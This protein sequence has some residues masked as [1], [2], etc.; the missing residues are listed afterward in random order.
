MKETKKS[1]LILFFVV[2]FA[3]F[4]LLSSGTP[5]RVHS[6]SSSSYVGAEQCGTCHPEQYTNWNQ[7]DHANMAG[8]AEIN[9]SGT[10]YWV[11][12]PTNV[13]NQTSF[14]NRCAKCH[15]TGW[16]SDT[17]TWPYWNSTDP[18]LAGKFLNV[19]CEK[20]HGPDTM[21]L[22]VEQRINYSSSLCGE[23]HT[24]Y[25]DWQHSAHN[26]SLT[27]LRASEHAADYC[28]RC[29]ST[30][31]F[32][33]YYN[34]SSNVEDV[35]GK[36]NLTNPELDPI[37]CQL[38]HNPHSNQ[39]EYQLRFENSTELCGQCHTGSHHPQYETFTE[40]PHEKAGLECA[41][42]HGQGTRLFHGAEESWFNH[43]FWIYNTFYPFN[44]TDPV[45]CSLCHTRSWATSQ[46]GVIQG[47]TTNLI[48][49]VTQAVD[50]AKT[51]INIANQTS[52]VN[53][54]QIDLATSM[55][56]TAETYI[57]S[58]ENDRSEGF[59]NP[60]QTFATLS[61]AAHLANKA[62]LLAF[63]ALNSEKTT[64]EAQVLSLQTQ[65][66]SL[67]NQTATLQSSIDSLEAKIDSLESTV[68][69]IPYLYGGI[70]LAIGFIIGAA[71]IFAIRKK[72][73]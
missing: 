70:G 27:D 10:F 11:A 24:Q 59:H 54:T 46:L 40:S 53:Q 34:F 31:S 61:E 6:S 72:K 32:V 44:Q 21:S 28:I 3:G 18:A 56:E 68:A 71:I 65:V 73:P 57:S 42:C 8:I 45:V 49:N 26:E 35:I 14:I 12:F 41:S 25:G 64:L 13:M 22:P 58:V 69:T 48:T 17:K 4:L 60:E 23:C 33:D 30:Q 52:G 29:H 50:N 66:I 2:I 20:C 55:V 16:D 36:I 38:C 5:S 67:Q 43:T 39:Y 63:E 1:Q 47:L 15:V 9:V 62:Q 7:T 19:Q 51:S 37:T